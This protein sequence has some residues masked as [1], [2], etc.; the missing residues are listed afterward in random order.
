MT[1]VQKHLLDKSCIFQ[2]YFSIFF[3]NVFIYL[4]QV[5]LSSILF[6][7]DSFEILNFYKFIS[8]NMNL[9]GFCI[10]MLMYNAG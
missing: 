7:Y 9:G 6:I 5:Y 8:V 4:C 3:L 1:P 10:F 2:K